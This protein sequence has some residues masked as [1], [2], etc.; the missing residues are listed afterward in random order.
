MGEKEGTKRKSKERRSARDRCSGKQKKKQ[1]SVENG[2]ITIIVLRWTQ[3]SGPF[4]R[5][6]ISGSIPNVSVLSFFLS[7]LFIPRSRR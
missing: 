5:E 2:Q 3:C 7:S 4:I 1:L 6:F